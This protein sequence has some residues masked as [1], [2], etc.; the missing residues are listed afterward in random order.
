M[1]GRVPVAS[2][3]VRTV[4]RPRPFNRSFL[5]LV[6]CDAEPKGAPFRRATQRFRGGGGRSETDVGLAGAAVSILPLPPKSPKLKPCEWRIQ[7]YAAIWH[8]RTNRGSSAAKR[9]DQGRHG[10]TGARQ[11]FLVPIP[12]G[13]GT[14]RPGRTARAYP[15]VRG[16]AN[17]PWTACFMGKLETPP[18]AHSD[19]HS[20]ARHLRL[21]NPHNRA[22]S[23]SRIANRSVTFTVIFI[24]KPNAAR[25]DFG[26][27][28]SP[29]D[30]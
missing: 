10:R 22:W 15:F 18:Q 11:I 29:F 20:Y 14:G 26:D 28:K 1:R 6:G 9:S 5:V 25:V 13:R 4:P 7:N 19:C 24:L 23:L 8:L 30:V 27:R 16:F 12:I 17:S 3:T 21:S 2:L